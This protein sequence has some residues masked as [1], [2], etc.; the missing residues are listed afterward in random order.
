MAL[1]GSAAMMMPLREPEGC[2]SQPGASPWARAK[3]EQPAAMC[4]WVAGP[5]FLSAAIQLSCPSADGEK[6]QPAG[7]A[8]M[9]SPHRSTSQPS[10][11][12]LAKESQDIWRSQA[13]R[14]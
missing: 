4:A 10:A 8:A 3:A 14:Q 7:D 12:L 2:D 11:A 1:A 6:A 5:V 13:A 9:M